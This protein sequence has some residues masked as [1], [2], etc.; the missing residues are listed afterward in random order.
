M[1]GCYVQSLAHRNRS[2]RGGGGGISCQV[3]LAVVNFAAEILRR[4]L[5]FVW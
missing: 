4:S 2:Y 3:K 1:G 5:N